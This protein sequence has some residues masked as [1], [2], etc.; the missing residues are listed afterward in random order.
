MHLLGIMLSLLRQRE[1]TPWESCRCSVAPQLRSVRY[2]R[3]KF[4]L[5]NRLCAL[6]N[7]LLS[8]LERMSRVW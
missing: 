3:H 6:L 2:D 8:F 4:L 1:S 5:S 7:R